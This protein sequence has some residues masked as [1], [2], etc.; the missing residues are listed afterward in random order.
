MRVLV[1]SKRQYTRKDLL[2]DCYGRLF[3]LPA[4]LA[5]IGHE[6]HGVAC[7]YRRRVGGAFSWPSHPRLTWESHNLLP[8][9]LIEF[10]RILDRVVE[11]FAPDVLWASS[12]AAHACLGAHLKRR[13]RIRL[14]VDLYDNYE[15]FGMSNLPGLKR[16]FVRAL[17]SADAVSVVTQA[18]AQRI[19]TVHGVRCPVA[20][21]G[22]GV[23]CKVFRVR[24]SKEARLQ[25]ELPADGILMGTAGALDDSRGI[26]DLTDA[27]RLILDERPE[28]SLVVAGARDRAF[29]RAISSL[30]NVI[31]LGS[32][33]HEEVSWLLSSLDVGV[34]CN[35]NSDFG[36]HCFPMK[37]AEMIACGVPLVAADV[38]VTSSLL[39]GRDRCLYPPGDSH[40]LADRILQQLVEPSILPASLISGW[41]PLA[42]QLSRVFVGLQ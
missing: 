7:S 27:F 31:D 12:D 21:I 33:T 20:V 11:S 25:L 19:E 34:I 29:G 23:D 4:G 15:A 8:F 37:L 1:I 42:E 16:A 36:R 13:H 5:A 38:G 26:C 2:D 24:P 14:V 22:N 41:R 28:A 6:V 40:Q 9:G 18:L 30:K 32:V 39:A 35:R 3:E 10:G 17:R